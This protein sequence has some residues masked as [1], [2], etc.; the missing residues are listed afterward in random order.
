[1][2]KE[3]RF[4]CHSLTF[5]LQLASFPVLWSTLLW[6]S[7]NAVSSLSLSTGAVP[8]GY[9]QAMPLC[10]LTSNWTRDANLTSWSSTL[11]LLQLGQLFWKR[12][13]ENSFSITKHWGEKKKKKKPQHKKPMYYLISGYSP[14]LMVFSFPFSTCVFSC[15]ERAGKK[16][17]PRAIG[18]QCRYP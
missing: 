10:S 3:A 2:R 11:I 1:M 6:E 17:R 18:R 13:S 9:S 8:N 4:C 16:A 12:Q 14:N 7:R 15:W 5:W